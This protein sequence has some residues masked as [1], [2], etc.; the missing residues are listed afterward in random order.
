MWF[1]RLRSALRRLWTSNDAETDLHD[2]VRAYADQL[3]DEYVASGIAPGEARRR[4]LIE[5]GGVAS[6]EESVRSV[7]SGAALEQWWQDVRYAVRGLRRTPAFTAT[8]IVTLGLGIGVNTS[9]FTVLNAALLKPVPYGRSEELVDVGHRIRAGT[10]METTSFGLSWPEIAL[11]RAESQLFQGAE[12]TGRPTSRNWKER[13]ELIFVSKFTP[14]LPA[15][16][17]VSPQAGRVFAAEEVAERAPV[18][19]ISDDLWSRAF[20][21]RADALGA[22]MTLDGAPMT[23]IG[24]MPPAFRF[25]PAGGGLAVAWVGQDA[26]L[27]PTVP[28]SGIASPVFRLKA[29]L[30]LDAAVP[31]AQAA[32]AR[33]QQAMPER[34]PWTVALSPLAS[35]RASVGG[36]V[37]TPLTLLLAATGL[38]LLVACANIA[39]LLS[40]RSIGRRHEL[41]LRAALGATRMRLARLLLV[42]GTVIAIGGSLIAILLAS[43]TLKA[44]MTL[45]PSRMLLRSG[46]FSVSLPELDWR[47]LMFTLGATV[48][49]TMLSALWPAVRGSNVGRLASLAEGGRVSGPTTERRRMSAVLQ[50]VQVALALVLATGAGLFASSFS[51]VLGADL[52]FDAEGL[53]SVSIQLPEATYKSPESQRRAFDE[54]IERLRL[55]RGVQSVAEGNPPPAT[56]GGRFVRSGSKEATGSLTLRSAGPGYFATAGIRLLAG[57]EFALADTESSMP[58]AIVDEVG[59]RT[60]FG[61]ESPLGQ[62]FSYSPYVPELTIIGVVNS[63]A[64][65]GFATGSDAVGMYLAQRQRSSTTTTL[66]IRTSAPGVGLATA[67]QEAIGTADRDIKVTGF[68]PVTDYYNLMGTYATPRFYLSLIS[69]FAMMALVTAAVGLYGLLAY[70]VG[71]RQR[72]IGVRVALGSSLGQIRWLVFAEAMRPVLAGLVMGVLGAWL[73]TGV[74][75]SFLYE[76]SPRDL[77]TFAWSVVVLLVVVLIATIGPIRRATGVDPIQA[78]RAE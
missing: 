36:R 7:R 66:I 60:L 61:G 31:I 42:E 4:A 39:N 1:S 21:R 71:Q 12:A 13:N 62:R 77:P 27:D 57:R 40:A 78:L 43:G 65:S 41:T 24:V 46:L 73:A 17:G 70:S 29:G 6:V 5:L 8:V 32:A 15:L 55:I 14:G 22:T 64:G 19:L 52:G 35:S 67:I 3:T 25:G 9:V 58:V 48:L 26:R 16:L 34:E 11:W 75:A 37:R 76:V 30:S 23:I 50:A 51:R 47:V 74:L 59:A 63:V 49:V 38:V 53:S 68:G 20:E 44:L 10:P 56:G 33:I 54:V 28:G 69:L 18:I 2:N 45:M 72:E